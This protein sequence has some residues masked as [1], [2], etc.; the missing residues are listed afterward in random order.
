MFHSSRLQLNKVC[1]LVSSLEQQ[2]A[3]AAIHDTIR[4]QPHCQLIS[5]YGLIHCVASLHNSAKQ[6]TNTRH[7]IMFYLFHVQVNNKL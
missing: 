5:S 4:M 6:R 3:M 2:A 7:E 1:Y